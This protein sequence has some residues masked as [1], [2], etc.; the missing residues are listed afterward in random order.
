M[1]REEQISKVLERYKNETITLKEATGII[2]LLFSVSG[3]SL[4]YDELSEIASDM[5]YELTKF[6]DGYDD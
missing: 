6:G 5:G 2:L 4:T 3:Q 1:E